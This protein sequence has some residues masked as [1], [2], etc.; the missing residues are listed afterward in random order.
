MW[1]SSG[2]PT[3]TLVYHGID[4][5]VFA[6]LREKLSAYGVQVGEASRGRLQA[7]GVS[8]EY[9][10]EE[11]AE[12]LEIR[13]FDRPFLVPHHLIASYFR[14]AIEEAGGRPA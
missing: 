7:F 11:A 10:W 8:G 6:R 12:T 5:A 4:Q 9:H 1:G 13:I 3:E 2:K 14:E